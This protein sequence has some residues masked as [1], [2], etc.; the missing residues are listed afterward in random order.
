[1]ET[2][3]LKFAPEGRFPAAASI[4]R[5]VDHTA[6]VGGYIVEGHVPAEDIK[7]VFRETYPELFNLGPAA[8]Q[9]QFV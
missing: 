2:S 5:L 6:K 7:R 4:I 3:S 9:R 8:A 1:L